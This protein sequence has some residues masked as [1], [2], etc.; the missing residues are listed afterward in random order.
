[1]GFERY[2]RSPPQEMV[3]ELEVIRLHTS[4]RERLASA[5]F[6]SVAL[7]AGRGTANYL[8]ANRIPAPAQWLLR[9]LPAALSSRLLTAA[10]TG[11]AWTFAGSGHC[12]VA[13]G[14]PL[15]I[16]I[17]GCAIC[18]GAHAAVP[19]CD[20]YTATFARLFSKLVDRRA[21]A[22]ETHCIANGAPSCRFEITWP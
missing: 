20:Y 13:R 1:M 9:A 14:P 8:L 6:H 10:I 17:Q 12:T 11:H 5:A 3:D 15:A 22:V 2:V 18:C 21:T 4:V 16:T 19:V 7:A